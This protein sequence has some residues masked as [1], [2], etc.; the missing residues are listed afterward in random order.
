MSAPFLGLLAV[1]A[2]VPDVPAP[3]P[4]SNYWIEAKP[5]GLAE[6]ALR[7]ALARGGFGGPAAAVDALRQISAN[8]PGTA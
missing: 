6:A 2:A 5:E 7:E 4:P 1:L 8:Y 3:N